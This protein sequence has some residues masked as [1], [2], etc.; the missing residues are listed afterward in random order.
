ML[1]FI[2]IAAKKDDW[3][4]GTCCEL[5]DLSYH[6]IRLG[7]QDNFVIPATKR[8]FFQSIHNVNDI[9]PLERIAQFS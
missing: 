3:S 2:R 6:T 4:Q 7:S 8:Y 9:R 1:L 5:K